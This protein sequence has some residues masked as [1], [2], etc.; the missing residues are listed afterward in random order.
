MAVQKLQHPNS[1]LFHLLDD[2]AANKIDLKNDTFKC[3]LF[4]STSNLAVTS[5]SYSSLTNEV[6][7]ANGY[8]TGGITLANTALTQDGA[9][10]EFTSDAP[11]WTASGGSITGRRYCVYSDT[12]TN[13]TIVGFALLDDTDADV[14]AT[15]GNTLTLTPTAAIGWFS[16]SANNA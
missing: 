8:V 5:T 15:D 13:K 12:N 16:G 1:F 3:A 9:A 11:V 14:T 10:V 4:L 7:N 2:T 6:A